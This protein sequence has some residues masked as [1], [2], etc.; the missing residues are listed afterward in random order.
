MSSVPLAESIDGT[1][2]HTFAHG[3]LFRPCGRADCVAP[4]RAQRRAR[5]NLLKSLKAKGFKA[6]RNTGEYAVYFLP[7]PDDCVNRWGAFYKCRAT[8]IVP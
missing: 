2:V 1:R 3:V 4:A 7:R 5:R 8:R 6:I